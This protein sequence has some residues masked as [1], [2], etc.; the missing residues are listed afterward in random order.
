MVDPQKQAEFASLARP[1]MEF[2]CNEFHPHVT[3]IITPTSAELLEGVV[4][5]GQVLDFMKD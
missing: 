3:V 5:T 4:S 1:L 2:L